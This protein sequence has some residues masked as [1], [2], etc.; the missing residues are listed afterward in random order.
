MLNYN[1]SL[2]HSH[3]HPQKGQARKSLVIFPWTK[4]IPNQFAIT[5]NC[6]R[7]KLN[8]YVGTEALLREIKMHSI[9]QD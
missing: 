6:P 9:N 8:F 7:W 3:S 1:I 5:I 4:S 2:S